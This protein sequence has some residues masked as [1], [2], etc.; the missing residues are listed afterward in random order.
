[1][2][3]RSNLCTTVETSVEHISFGF[4]HETLQKFFSVCETSKQI[5]ELEN[6]CK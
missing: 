6:H 3:I 2:L 4:I 5:L 1:M